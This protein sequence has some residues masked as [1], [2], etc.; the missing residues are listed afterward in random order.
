M[1]KNQNKNCDNVY[2]YVT[3]RQ[4]RVLCISQRNALEQYL[5]PLRE[6]IKSTKNLAQRQTQVFTITLTD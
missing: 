4:F 2:F 5:T 3:Q 1:I 6:K